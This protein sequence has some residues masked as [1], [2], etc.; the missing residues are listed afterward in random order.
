MRTKPIIVLV[1][2]SL[3]TLASVAVGQN[4]QEEPSRDADQEAQELFENLLRQQMEPYQP[5]THS[6]SWIRLGEDVG[7]ELFTDRHGVQR[8][9]LYVRRKATW[10]PVALD[11]PREIGPPV[12]ELRQR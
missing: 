3:V 7:L 2:L 1:V 8:G 5:D 12:L 6:E 10:H 11:G 4:G 9:R